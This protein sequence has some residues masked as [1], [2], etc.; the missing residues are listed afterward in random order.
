MEYKYLTTVR[1]ISAKLNSVDISHQTTSEM[2]TSLKLAGHI[3]PQSFAW[4][5]PKKERNLMKY[6]I[7]K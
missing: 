5:R 2:A 6:L 3:E 1:N 4:Y 7:L